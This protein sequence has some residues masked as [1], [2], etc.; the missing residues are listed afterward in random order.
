MTFWLL[1]KRQ[2]CHKVEFGT[3]ACWTEKRVLLMTPPMLYNKHILCLTCSSIA[4]VDSDSI[5]RC[6]HFANL[7]NSNS[8]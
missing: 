6:R 5:S 2:V 3:Q 1:R 8:I 7:E 4:A